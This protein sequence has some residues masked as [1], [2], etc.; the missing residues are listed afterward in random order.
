M[1]DR[2]KIMFWQ[3]EE[4][5]RLASAAIPADQLKNGFIVRGS[6][7]LGDAVMTFPCL[8]QLRTI[9]PDGCPLIVLTPAGLAPLYRALKGTVD[10]IITLKDAH[11][12]PAPEE[13]DAIRLTHARAG[14][15]FNNS[16]R[17]AIILRRAGIRCL[18]GASARFRS[19]L[20]KKSWKF[21]KR[22]DHELNRPHQ[23]AKYLAMTYALGAQVWDG[24]MPAMTPTVDNADLKTLLE[25]PHVL[26][27][28]P[29]A[30]YGDGKR[31]NASGF[32]QVAA[33][34]LERHPAGLV[35]ALGSK[36]ERSGAGEA[37][38]G[39]E[40]QRVR[41]LAGETSIDELML[42]LQKSEM[43]LANDSGIMHL[44]AALGGQGVAVFGSTDPAATSPVSGKWKLL[45]D[46]L[47]C[48]PCFKRVCP[49]GTKACLARITPGDVT[50]LMVEMG[51]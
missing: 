22:R 39:L 3:P 19:L 15:L 35:L 48:S 5:P 8:K 42:V 30:A 31:W 23:A 12:F 16:L 24:I 49:L 46:K 6:N 2:S 37:I 34:W 13:M 1:L 38:E 14:M 18:Y 41:N 10:Q 17:D 29:G 43:C 4:A 20:L 7:W 45:Y 47:P 26:A 36:A 21:P 11:A 27:V 9:L 33:W 32:R 25:N 50:D 28:A 40:P 51:V 44:S